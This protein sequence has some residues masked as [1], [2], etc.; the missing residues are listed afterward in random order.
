MFLYIC[1]FVAIRFLFPRVSFVFVGLSFLFARFVLYLCDSFSVSTSQFSICA[2]PFIFVRLSFIFVRFALYLC[3][4]FC[5]C[6]WQL[7]ATVELS[8][9]LQLFLMQFPSSLK[10]G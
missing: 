8:L 7:W 4:S 1:L 5:I 3:D 9:S 10:H 2:T 6:A